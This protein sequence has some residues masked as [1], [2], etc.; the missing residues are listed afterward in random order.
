MRN[1]SFAL[2]TPQFLARN[3]TVTRRNGWR[4]LKVG[5]VLC[6]VEKGQGLKR[7]E[8]VVRLGCIK[9]TDVRREPLRRLLDDAD[10]G[11]AEVGREAFPEQSPSEFVEFFC[12]THLGCTPDS[13]VTRIK[14]VFLD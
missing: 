11:S 13:E 14:Y 12:R 10:Y 6:A 3:K 2:T 9:V 5:E 7:G 4:K 8:K 1:I